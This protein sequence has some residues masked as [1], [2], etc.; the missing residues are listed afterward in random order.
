MPQQEQYRQRS[1]ALS[2]EALELINELGL[3]ANPINYAVFFAYVEKSND[4]LVALIDI[5][6]GNKRALDDV[7][8]HELYQ[9]FIEPSRAELLRE[10]MSHDLHRQVSDLI[11]RLAKGKD[12]ISTAELRDAA[13]DL[14]G[15]ENRANAQQSA[16]GVNDTDPAPVEVTQLLLDLEE[17]KREAHTDGLTG[18]AN[19][20]AFDESLRDAAMT[21]MERGEPLSVLLIDI[22]HFKRVN[23]K[24]GHQAGDQVIRT[25]AK[26][27]QQNVKGRDTTA[28]YGGEEFAV[29][30]PA[31]TLTDAMRVAENIRASIE[32]LHLRSFNRNEDLGR[33]TASVGVATYQLGE[34]LTRVIDRADQALYLAK[35]NGRN[36]VMNQNDLLTQPINR[37]ESA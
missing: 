21:T 11:D 1:Y 32:S 19:R 34:P 5:L 2:R 13:H 15:M 30:L 3:S 36:C 4:D 23:D 16:K 6:R 25:L 27:L 24:H 8:C 12:V 20:K 17:M 33:I 28:R 7:K 18:I 22:D 10:T 31:T 35:A 37:A 9:R 14:L 26:T 29:V